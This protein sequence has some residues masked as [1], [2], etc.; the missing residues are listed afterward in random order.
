MQVQYYFQQIFQLTFN[1]FFSLVI[2]WVNLSI[3][4][5]MFNNTVISSSFVFISIPM[6]MAVCIAAKRK[7]LPYGLLQLF[8]GICIL[9]T[10]LQKLIMCNVV[11]CCLIL[12][13]S[14]AIYNG[15]LNPN[16]Q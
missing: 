14:N 11:L 4:L 6:A 1:F 13:N 16:F 12:Y 15:D 5:D 7:V 2:G 10:E 3:N 8:T 9:V